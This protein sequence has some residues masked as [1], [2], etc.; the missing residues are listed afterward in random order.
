MIDVAVI[1]A[2]S[3]GIAAAR[4]LVAAGFSVQLLEAR[5]RVGGRCVT[6]TTTLGAAADLGAAWL[7][8]ADESPWT[9]LAREQGL[10]VI[11]R[12][13]D[14]G[15]QSLVAGRRPTAAE[16]AEAEAG[17]ERCWSQVGAAAEAGL[18]VPV[19]D[20]L[21]Q[22]GFRPRFDAVMTWIMGVES[23]AVSC[24]DLARYADSAHDWAVAEGIGTLVAGAARGL[25]VSLSTPVSAVDWSDDGVT[26]STSRGLVHARSAIVTLP[27]SVL[28]RG[29]IRFRPGL[30]EA[31]RTALESLPLGSNNKVFFRFDDTDLPLE[32]SAHCLVRADT[33][34]TVHLGVRPAD[35]PLVMAYFGGDLS[36]ELEAGGGLEDFARESLVATF[37]A[38]LAGRIRGT[39]ITGWDKDPWAG[40]SYTA[41]RPGA[42]R[43]REVLASPVSPRLLFAGEACHAHHYGTIYGAWQSGVAA[44]RNL[45]DT[46]RSSP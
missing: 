36:R 10:T 40:G 25:P 18:D 46:L 45:I 2:G 7:H 39:L 32:S 14:W 16:Q 19:S 12:D 15:A 35:Q 44:A 34:R 38:Q 43:Q 4:C 26:L 24:L 22:D 8:F 33:S 11:E 21:P 1:G 17:F 30:P 9:Q 41:A 29:D 27:T 5:G 20:L 3:A 31:Q 6:D 28:A 42:A 13:P 37:G 23:P